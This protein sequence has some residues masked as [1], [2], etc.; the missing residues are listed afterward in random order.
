MIFCFIIL[1]K[2]GKPRFSKF[3]E[4]MNVEEQQKFVKQTFC[5]ISKKTLQDCNFFFYKTL[6][7]GQEAKI[8]FRR[9]ATLYIIVCVNCCES[10]LGILDL[11]QV[12]VEILDV[13]FP[14]VCE[15]HLIY[16]TEKVHQI[17]DEII[18]GGIVAETN[19]S[20][21]FEALNAQATVAKKELE[22]LNKV[23]LEYDGLTT[24]IKK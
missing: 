6:I 17:L 16:H 22:N 15:L 1:N 11:I 3:Y 7:N 23:L 2:H 4:R 20:L 18:V 24:I 21:V 13:Y 12:F 10:E 19:S 14:N 9:Y 5:V 8:I